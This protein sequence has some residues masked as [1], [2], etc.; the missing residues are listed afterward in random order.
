MKYKYV[1][2]GS[3]DDYYLASYA[4]VFE[5]EQVVYRKTEMDG[6]SKLLVWLHDKH[7][8]KR[9]NSVIN[10]P[11]KAL[12]NNLYFPNS[13]S[14]NDKICFLLFA[15]YT[16]LI[17]YGLI[18]NLRARFP[19]CKIVCFYQDLARTMGDI[20]PQ[21][22]YEYFDLVLSFDH[23]DC[24]KY[25]FIYYPLVYS[26]L[27]VESDPAIQESELYFV[28]KVKNRFN[29]IIAIFEKCQTSGIKCDFHIVGVPKEQQV[30]TDKIDYC[31][32]MPYA[33][34]L[35]RIQKTKCMLEI[36]QKGGH[37]YTLRY[38]EAI[39]LGKR[40]ITNNTEITKADF[41]NKKFIST[42]QGAEDFDVDF[43]SQGEKEVD[44][45]FIDQLS[46]LRLLEF[47]DKRL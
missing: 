25:G 43:I 4:D 46:P 33:E 36:M 39:A 26:K 8:G 10:V 23:E 16:K 13:Y 37:G 24:E 20:N 35:K 32:Q 1:I 6:N 47:V 31:T 21:T 29:D 3:P 22:V 30:H 18:Q 19:K 27:K 45:H 15:R 34:N 7:F 11:G 28:G 17:K 44:Y 2:G 42:F 9:V 12:W 14:K 38:C 40:L 5:K 41:Y